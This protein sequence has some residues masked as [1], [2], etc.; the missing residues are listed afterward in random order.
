MEKSY[1]YCD[2]AA[3]TPV[4]KRVLKAMMPFFTKDF[5]NVH[6]QHTFGKTAME[7]VDDARASVADFF[8]V[9][10]PEVVF[11]S[12]ATESNNLALRGVV[13][14]LR[15]KEKPLHMI[16][17]AI[18][19]PSVSE[20][21]KDLESEGVK[22]SVVPVQK[23]G[24]VR[25][26]DVVSRITDE[27]CLV[28]IMAANN[29]IGTI[30]PIDAI[31][32][33]LKKIQKT[34]PAG[35]L[36]LLFHT[37]ATQAVP[38]LDIP[39]LIKHVDLVSFSGHKCYGPKGIGGLIVREKTPLARMQAG[40]SHEHNLRAGTLNVPAIVG[41]SKAL[42]FLP[43]RDEYMRKLRDRFEKECLTKISNSCIVGAEPRLPHISNIAFEGIDQQLFV[44]YADLNEHLAVSAGSAC[45]SGAHEPSATITA[46]GIPEKLRG[47]TIRF[48]F[49][50]QTTS[51][52]IREVVNRCVR[53]AKA[54]HKK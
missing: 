27:T 16:V 11:T 36:P 48:S 43:Y 5:G 20:T 34:R 22:V 41:L 40:G 2:Y 26:Q 52:E 53:I 24:H 45:A 7:A 3:T 44:V 33:E 17:S 46:L 37:D 47:T 38:W 9:T 13:K 23:T 1:I 49:G 51:Q 15:K 32:R 39:T 8:G 50:P 12:G 31:G 25:V 28:S 54:L 18:E 35:T 10:T 29:E 19:H 6:S 4:D 42:S 30:Q 14:A 21:A